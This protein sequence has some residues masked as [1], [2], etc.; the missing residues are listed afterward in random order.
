MTPHPAT[1]TALQNVVVGDDPS[2]PEIRDIVAYW[3]AKRGTRWAPTRQDIDPLELKAHLPHL[4]M[5]DSIAGGAD[6]RYR[7]I[8]TAIAEGLGRDSTGQLISQL[9]A[10]QPAALQE[11]RA[12]FGQALVRRAPYFATGQV[13]WLPSRD[14]LNFEGGYMPLSDE[15]DNVAMIL[16]R[17][18]IFPGTSW[19]PA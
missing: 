17:L 4:F 16:A 15:A 7:L 6:Y 10:N 5:I 18:N 13:F 3:N 2:T 14:F 12:V 1:N 19:T 11:L 9:Y 8:G